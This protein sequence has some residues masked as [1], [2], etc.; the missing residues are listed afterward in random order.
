MSSAEEQSARPVRPARKVTL[1]R[2]IALLITAVSILS[3]VAAWRASVV[4]GDAGSLDQ[5]ATQERVRKQQIEGQLDAVVQ[6]DLRLFPRYLT[7]LRSYQ[8]LTKRAKA[9]EDEDAL[10]AGD[11]RRD[12][13]E[14]LALTRL[15][16][17]ELYF[18]PI[19]GDAV[20]DEAGARAYLRTTDSDL[21][22]LDPDK[23]LD[24]AQEERDRG[25]T[26]VG[27]T[28]LFIGALFFLTLAQVGRRLARKGFALVGLLLMMG[29]S[30]AFAVVGL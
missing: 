3:A 24:L 22:S 18:K 28:A 2:V 26:L 16:Y 30:I 27:V 23:A 17:Q 8:T 10:L 21:A 14:E 12:A 6:Q 11:L 29:A 5:R 9:K 20:Y 13:G 7:H 19:F 15:L 25:T 4:S 1:V